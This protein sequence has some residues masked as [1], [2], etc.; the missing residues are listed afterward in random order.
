MKFLNKIHYKSLST[1]SRPVAANLR[2]ET[3]DQVISK[4]VAAFNGLA[5]RNK[6]RSLITKLLQVTLAV[7]SRLTRSRV[8]LVANFSFM[9]YRL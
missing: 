1:L 9:V 3:L 6:G 8:A 4:R 5:F 7:N 2:S